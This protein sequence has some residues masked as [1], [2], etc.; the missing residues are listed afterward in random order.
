MAFWNRRAQVVAPLPLMDMLQHIVVPMFAL[1]AQGH[2]AVWNE[3]CAVL[4]GLSATEVLGTKDHWRGFYKAARPC[5]ADLVLAGS[6]GSAGSLYAAANTQSADGRMVAQ[7][8]CDLPSGKRC[9]LRIDAGPLRNPAGDTLYVVET[10][11]DYTAIKEAEAAI[12]A[13]RRETA[14]QQEDVVGALAQGLSALARGDLRQRLTTAFSPQYEQLRADFNATLGRLG[15]VMQAVVDRTGSVRAG[16]TQMQHAADDL[17]NGSRAAGA[18]MD[19]TASTLQAVTAT[20]RQTTD[21]AGEARRVVGSAHEEAARSGGVVEQAVRAMG[22]IAGSS[23]QIGN[24]IGVIDEIAFQT[25]LLALNAGVEAA[26]AGEAGRGFAVVATEVRALAQRSADAAK[27][28]KALITASGSQVETG[29]RLV[30]EAGEALSRIIAHVEVLN[31]LIG[32]IAESARGQAG[33]LADVNGAMG[34]LAGIRKGNSALTNGVRD[35]SAALTEDAETLERLMAQFQ[36][37]GAN[38]AMARLR[39]LAG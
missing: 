13:E 31:G 23:R 29:V 34:E 17:A 6:T 25:N 9:Y 7:N 27:E 36:L 15:E 10:L 24:I 5:L 21:G 37:G 19:H 35:A 12:D 3:A 2:V 20:V 1:D 22:E 11:Q 4:T 38:A 39:E 18:A 16:A 14:R 32:T 28:I 33:G 26:R 30:G 8:W